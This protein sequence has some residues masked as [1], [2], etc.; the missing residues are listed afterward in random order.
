M[1]AMNRKNN[2]RENE[3]S[4]R[5][6]AGQYTRGCSRS[7]S[8]RWPS[9]RSLSYRRCWNRMIELEVLRS[10]WPC[11]NQWCWSME[12]VTHSSTEYSPTFLENAASC[13][14]HHYLQGR[15]ITFPSFRMHLWIVSPWV[16]SIT[17]PWILEQHTTRTIGA[18]EGMPRSI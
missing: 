15:S 4:S 13:S 12:R 5:P 16:E 1:A 14:F 11:S 10:M 6:K 8:C 9:W 18:T 17:K 7:T 3:A 2:R